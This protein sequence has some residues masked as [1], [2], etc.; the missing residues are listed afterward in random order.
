MIYFIGFSVAANIIGR[1]ATLD[2]D[3]DNIYKYYRVSSEFLR[4][5]S[6]AVASYP[7]NFIDKASES[8]KGTL[9]Q[10]PGLFT[11]YNKIE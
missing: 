7:P 6:T 9:I 1:N 2:F 5:K 11:L 10:T 8:I 3:C 4:P